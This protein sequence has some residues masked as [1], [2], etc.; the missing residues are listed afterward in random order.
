VL[1]EQGVYL[2]DDAILQGLRSVEWPARLEVLH[3]DPLIVIDGAHNP[4]SAACLRKAVEGY[5]PHRRLHLIFGIS[6]DKD[7][8]GIVDEL[9]PIT[10]RVL[11]CR[12]RHYRSRSLAD[13]VARFQER[14]V[15]AQGCS[16][17]D[18]A[19]Q[20]AVELAEPGDL[21]LG[22]GSIFTVAE[23]REKVLGIRLEL[24]PKTKVEEK[25]QTSL[26]AR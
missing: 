9:A 4:H 20:A 16:T 15:P 18:E 7:L 8:A 6:A 14:G 24:Y 26:M 13:I 12:S 3:I 21:I 2:P 25:W 11:A 1:Q 23:I 5:L 22:A 19:I 10:Y 17:I